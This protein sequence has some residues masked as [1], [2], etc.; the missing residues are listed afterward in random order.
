VP[1]RDA[2]PVQLQIDAFAGANHERQVLDFAELA[3]QTIH[4]DPTS[5]LKEFNHRQLAKP[6]QV[7][8]LLQPKRLP[9][10]HKKANRLVS[11]RTKLELQIP[12]TEGLRDASTAYLHLVNT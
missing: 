7:E 11:A 6:S 5:L 4:S 12:T 10:G 3:R 2:L 8:P 9:G 1:L